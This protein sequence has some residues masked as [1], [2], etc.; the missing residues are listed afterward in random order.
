MPVNKHIEPDMRISQHP[1]LGQDFT[2]SPTASRA[3]AEIGVRAQI[4]RKVAGGDTE[5]WSGY[6]WLFSTLAALQ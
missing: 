3:Q 5:V 4:A 1:A 6:R 2:P